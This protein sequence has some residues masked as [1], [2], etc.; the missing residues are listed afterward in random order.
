MRYVPAATA[1][2]AGFS[3]VGT[4]TVS[5]DQLIWCIV[6]S[7]PDGFA[8][9]SIRK[10]R[11]TPVIATNGLQLVSTGA[12]AAGRVRW[13]SREARRWCKSEASWQSRQLCDDAATGLVSKP[14]R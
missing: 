13:A 1:I 11:T 7:P 9:H 6:S 8:R 14:E 4:S 2:A 3:S 5:G 12:W 10:G